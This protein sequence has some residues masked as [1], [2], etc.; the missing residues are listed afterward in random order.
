MNFAG[1]IATED[2]R[3]LLDE[4]ADILHVAVEWIDGDGSVSNDEFVRTSGRHGCFAYL[5]GGI[6]FAEPCCF[7]GCHNWLV[8][9]RVIRQ[10]WQGQE[11]AV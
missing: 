1:N 4:D 3:P 7:V 11:D 6:G 5:Q 10:G 9:S 8:L 2:G